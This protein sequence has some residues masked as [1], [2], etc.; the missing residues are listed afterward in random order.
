MNQRIFVKVA[1]RNVGEGLLPG[2]EGAEM[3]RTQLHHVKP[4]AAQ[5][6]AQEKQECEAH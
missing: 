6:T 4:T 2:A 1:Y 3:T 5:V